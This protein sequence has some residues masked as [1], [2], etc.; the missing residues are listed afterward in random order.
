MSTAPEQAAAED[1]IFAA[2][3]ERGLNDPPLTEAQVAQWEQLRKPST[4][5]AIRK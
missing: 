2:A 1:P 5:D 3:Y 4:P